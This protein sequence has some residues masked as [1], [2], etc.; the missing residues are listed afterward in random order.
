MNG[1]IEQ[2]FCANI[3]CPNK[4]TEGEFTVIRTDSA[5]VGDTW[6]LAFFVCIPCSLALRKLLDQRPIDL[7]EATQ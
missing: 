1:V 5:V 7:R 4:P 3:A 2:K 6:P